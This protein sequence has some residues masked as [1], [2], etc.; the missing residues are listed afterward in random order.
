LGKSGAKHVR[1]A[2]LPLVD[3]ES[4]LCSDGA[5]IYAAFAH[6]IGITHKVINDKPGQR[7]RNGAFHIQNVNAFTVG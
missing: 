3:H 2:L 5:A 1:E 7:V 6:T 4:V